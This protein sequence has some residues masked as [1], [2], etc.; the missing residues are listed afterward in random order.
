MSKI[1]LIGDSITDSHRGAD[2]EGL[3]DGYVRLLRDFYVT[4]FPGKELLFVNK[5][6]S[7]DRITDLEVRW[8]EDVLEEKPDWVSVSIG[9]NDV[10]RQLDNPGMDQV[11]P[12]QFLTIYR[13]LLQQAAEKTDS[14]LIL[15]QPT[16]IEEK[17]SSKG[18]QLLKEYVEIVD[19]LAKEYD[20]ILVPLHKV[21]ISYLKKNGPVPLTT[22]GVHMTTTGNMLMFKTWREAVQD[23]ITN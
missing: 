19:Q 9:I 14:R 4:S 23:Y 17:P 21:F 3:G 11:Q 2:P 8:Q 13:R 20:A 18:N 7:A 16:V 6:V 5:G 22:D 10:W 1:V 12:E 15:M